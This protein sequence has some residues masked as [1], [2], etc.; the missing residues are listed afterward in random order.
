MLEAKFDANGCVGLIN[1][2]VWDYKKHKKMLQVVEC[3]LIISRK[4]QWNFKKCEKKLE[5][6]VALVLEDKDIFKGVGVHLWLKYY[7]C[8]KDKLW[9]E[10]KYVYS[11]LQL[12]LK[13]QFL[14]QYFFSN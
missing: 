3:N 9:K 2:V 13:S 11:K 5:F 12:K 14:E 7:K 1:H 6:F 8:C 4:I 10:E